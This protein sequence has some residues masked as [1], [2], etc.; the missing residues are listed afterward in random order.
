MLSRNCVKKAQMAG[1]MKLF[2]RAVFCSGVVLLVSFFFITKTGTGPIAWLK[3]LG[4]FP[5]K[6]EQRIGNC[7]KNM[8]ICMSAPVDML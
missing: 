2:F 4:M 5:V 7:A 6:N 3:F 1:K 8:Q